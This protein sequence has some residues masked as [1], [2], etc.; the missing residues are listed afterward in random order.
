[1]EAV[2]LQLSTEPIHPWR[3]AFVCAQD[4]L[5]VFFYFDQITEFVGIRNVKEV[6]R[7]HVCSSRFIPS[8]I[9]DVHK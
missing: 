3:S 9:H 2:A 6:L 4:K 7:Q 1:M 5:P 8:K